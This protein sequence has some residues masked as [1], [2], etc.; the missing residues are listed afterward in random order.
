M[1]ELDPDLLKRAA[2]AV[3]AFDADRDPG[4]PVGL[5]GAL[6]IELDDHVPVVPAALSAALA[7]FSSIFFDVCAQPALAAF[8]FHRQSL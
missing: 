3:L 6:A 8:H 5:D 7:F 1:D 2:G 4:K